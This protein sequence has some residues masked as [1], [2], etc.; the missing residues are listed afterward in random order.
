MS[1]D[2]TGI[3]DDSLITGSASNL[4]DTTLGAGTSG[5]GVAFEDA[6]ESKKAEVGLRK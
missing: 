5:S 6:V 2:S 1:A 4:Y 3:H